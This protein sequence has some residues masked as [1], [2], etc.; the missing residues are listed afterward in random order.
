MNIFEEQ[1]TEGLATYIHS[2]S[3]TAETRSFEMVVFH[4]PESPRNFRTIHSERIEDY[5]DI[6]IDDDDPDLTE[7]IIGTN[8]RILEHGKVEILFHTDLRE[9]TFVCNGLP[10]IKKTE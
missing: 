1:L 10:K 5:Q 3:Y 6:L 7:G 4:N 9:I 2:Y 8:L